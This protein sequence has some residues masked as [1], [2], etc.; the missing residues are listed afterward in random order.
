MS[1]SG[2]PSRSTPLL[3]YPPHSYFC[4]QYFTSPTPRPLSCLGPFQQR[5]A[6]NSGEVSRRIE[7]VLFSHREESGLNIGH[8]LAESYQKSSNN[9]PQCFSF[10]TCLE[11]RTVN[12]CYKVLLLNLQESCVQLKQIVCRF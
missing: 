12:Y 9:V 8:K 10:L 4:H 5:T 2:S 11:Y 7:R 3:K 6:G 1:K